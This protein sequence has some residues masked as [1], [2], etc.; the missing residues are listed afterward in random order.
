MGNMGPVC[1]AARPA[2]S[3]HHYGAALR[4]SA[5]RFYLIFPA[6]P[7]RSCRPATDPRFTKVASDRA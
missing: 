3:A 5:A 1:H 6:G 4:K 2:P 7:H